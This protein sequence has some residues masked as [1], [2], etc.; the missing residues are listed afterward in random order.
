MHQERAA[1]AVGPRDA[2]DQVGPRRRR[3]EQFDVEAGLVQFRGD[4]FGGD[5]FTVDPYGIGLNK[6]TDAKAFVNAFLQ[7]IYASGDW[8]KLWKATIGTVIKGDAPQPPKIGSVP[9]S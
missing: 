4:V 8:A 7:K 6:S 9:G 5:P 3:L 1:A 2:G